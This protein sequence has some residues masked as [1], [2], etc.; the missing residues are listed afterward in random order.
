MKKYLE[1]IG[2]KYSFLLM[3]LLG[4]ILYFTITDRWDVYSAPLIKKIDGVRSFLSERYRPEDNIIPDENASPSTNKIQEEELNQDL[5]NSNSDNDLEGKTQEDT[6]Q[7][8]TPEMLWQTV[9]EE[10]FEDALFI[11]DSRTVGMQ[12]YGKLEDK[13]VF[14]A[15]TGLTIYKLLTSKIV[16]VENSRHKK[17][18]AEAL[19]E[20]QFG[21]IYIMVGINELDVGTTQRFADTYR[22]VVE[23]ICELQP[24]AII[25]IQSIL[26]VTQKRSEQGDFLTNEGIREKNLA[27]RE[28][29]DNQKIY[30][31][32]VDRAVCSEDGCL[33]PEYTTDG[34][35]LKARYI[36]LWK[37]YLL[38]HAIAVS[39]GELREAEQR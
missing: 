7:E 33:I 27:I 15:S 29:A 24:N 16:P 13:A 14:Y 21:K 35:H 3:L 4:G 1:T 10:Y 2:K 17:T 25:Y 26:P 31:L 22:E 23:R 9:G 32:D 6:Q 34:V 30:Y 19:E 8:E 12:E 39:D 28:L 36:P 38:S 20:R 37:E 11:G 18:V 5:I